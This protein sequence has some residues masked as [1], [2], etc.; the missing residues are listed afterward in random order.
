V[1]VAL[2]QQV[3]VFVAQAVQILYLMQLHR[4]VVAVVREEVH[5]LVLVVMVVLAVA[6]H[7]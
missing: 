5:P 3:M 1:Q 2:A 6:Q 7:F 4:Q